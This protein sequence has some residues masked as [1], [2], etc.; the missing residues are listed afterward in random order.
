M[1]RPT[2]PPSGSAVAG[3]APKKGE[4]NQNGRHQTITW[5]ASDPNNGRAH[6]TPC[7][8]AG[9]VRPWILLKDKLTEATYDWDTRTAA[10]GRYELKVTAS[11]AASNPP[12]RGKTATRI[13]T[14]MLVGQH[15]PVIGD[16]KSQQNGNAVKIDPESR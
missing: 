1:R 10:H 5:K 8:S 15:A 13:A 14:P 2:W 12:A 4:A 6:R 16:V 3:T 9:W 11:D 7:S